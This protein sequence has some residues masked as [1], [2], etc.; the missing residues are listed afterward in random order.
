MTH[1]NFLTTPHERYGNFV[2]TKYLP[3]PELNCILRE[4]EHLPSGALVMHI[5]ND[6][7]ENLFCLSFKTF[8][9]S[10]NGA[11][12]IL[13]HTVLC[14]SK[15]FPVKDPFFSMSRR[16]LNT[17]MNALTGADFTCYPA[18]SQNEK[19]F[20]NLLDVYV[21]A[22][23]HPEL[24]EMSF[25]QE[26][27]HLEFTD[28]KDI[29]TPLQIRGIVFNE[30]K[31]SLASADSRIWHAL[32]EFLVP[33][34]PYTY[35]SGGDPKV[36]P[37]LTY[38]ELLSFHK[39]YYHPSQ[40]LFFFYGD[41]PLKTHLDVLEQGALKGVE[42]RQ[43]P[44]A[45]VK[46]RR[47]K[48]PLQKEGFYPSHASDDTTPRSIVTF[49]FLTASIDNQEEILALSV[50][51]AILM[52][53]DASLLKAP[54]LRSNLCVHV[55]AYIDTEMSEVPYAIVCKGC[56]PA[57]IHA[58]E[59]TLKKALL[60][61]IKKGIPWETI[62]AAL[63]QLEFSRLEINTEHAPFGLA[64]FMR[65]ALAKQHGCPPEQALVV[66]SIFEELL[67]KCKH[68]SYLIGLIEKYFIHNTHQVRLV[69]HPDPL[70]L[71]KETAQEQEKLKQL[72]SELSQ[73]E[74]QRILRQTETLSTFQKHVEKQ[75]LD[76]LPKVSLKDVE[77]QTRH[78]PLVEMQ[79]KHLK[80]YH[81]DC[82][83]NHIVYA[84]LLFDLPHVEEEDLPYLHLLMALLP[85]LGCGGRSYEENLRYIQAHTGGIGASCALN[86]QMTLPQT[87]RPSLG[88]KGKAL[89]RNMA[90]LFD[91]MQQ[92][93]QC[94]RFDDKKRIEELIKQL[95]ESL[96]NQLN[97]K[98]LLYAN[99]LA[100]S[101]FSPAAYVHQLWFGLDYFKCIESIT[102]DLKRNLMPLVD[103]LIRLKN[104]LFSFHN[105]HLVLSCSQEAL[106]TLEENAYF[107]LSE[108]SS[109]IPFSPL[110]LDTALRPVVSQVREIPS[111]VAFTS[112]AF[113]SVIYTHPDAAALYASTALF[114][115]KI[116]HRKIREQGGAYGC[117]ATYNSTLGHFQFHAYRDPHL[118][119]TIATFQEAIESI[120]AGEFS[121]QDLEEAKLGLIQQ[122]DIPLAP[123]S[124]ALVA[125]TWLRDGKTT[126][127]RQAFRDRF[128]ALNSAQVQA[129]VK[130]HLLS[131]KNQGVIVSLA[132]KD[133]LK[134]ENTML[135]LP[136]FPI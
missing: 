117:G 98:A 44:L 130:E 16:S 2:V 77:K 3:I 54:L 123:S 63:H 20:Y 112:E 12:H 33:D 79:K 129:A 23:F 100:S 19:D 45:L 11:P 10:S 70:L 72:R 91:L 59:T 65:A 115:N 53:D 1:Q 68:P 27:H 80:I 35:N 64:L 134:K 126:Q 62:E 92:M 122:F 90:P 93:L 21:D 47:F 14:G 60:S 39:K 40:C 131:R 71:A 32:M 49:G 5:G 58:L 73:E 48:T 128:L 82:F 97:K 83:T 36:I 18:A 50:L 69:M 9:S 13:E 88:I 108:L 67:Q 132:G 103:R 8:P 30:M 34:L 120:A 37:D 42:K 86:V 81:H 118:A 85:E 111:Q 99:Q 102:K 95:R 43:K 124:R 76:C 107:D 114:D 78:L 4:I 74:I 24:K 101:G 113:P 127:L 119:S 29:T 51:D 110:K 96:V 84:D 61:I 26:G 15:K 56:D 22:V 105:L 116:L 121:T 55:D 25:L 135:K 28:P 52:E 66:H 17:F 104:Q 31:G 7:P 106:K 6:D 75:S 89:V 136:L 125:Y 57:D 41:L 46:Q 38:Q 87:I 94:P 109:T 133:L